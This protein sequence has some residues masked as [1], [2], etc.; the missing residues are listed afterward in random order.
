MGISPTRS[1]RVVPSRTASSVPEI[2]VGSA[3][4]ARWSTDET[5]DPLANDIRVALDSLLR[6]RTI[7][8]PGETVIARSLLGKGAD[9]PSLIWTAQACGA[10]F[11]MG[12][13]PDAP[14]LDPHL[15]VIEARFADGNWRNPLERA[16]RDPWVLRAR[17]ASWCLACLSEFQPVGESETGPQQRHR[18][19][20]EQAYDMLVGSPNSETPARWM[21]PKRGESGWSEVWPDDAQGGRT[22]RRLNLLTSLY[23]VLGIAR[24]ERHGFRRY[25]DA[26]QTFLRDEQ[27]PNLLVDRLLSQIHVETAPDGPLVRLRGEDEA[28]PWHEPWA[29]AR[30]LPP[31]VIGL[32]AL[33]LV[34]YARF[35]G[36]IVEPDRPEAQLARAAF[37]K[38]QRLGHALLAR[39]KLIDVSWSRGVD[40]FFQQGGEDSAWFVPSYSICLRAVLETGVATPTHP[41]VQDALETISTFEI[42][43]EAG[44]WLDP[45]YHT[46]LDAE[47]EAKARATSKT[48]RGRPKLGSAAEA[49]TRHAEVDIRLW[50]Q[51]RN[52]ESEQWRATAASVHAAAMALSATRRA[53]G[54]VDPRMMPRVRARE[55][56]GN[57]PIRVLPK[58][59][60]SAIKITDGWDRFVIEQRDGDGEK[61][62]CET[63]HSSAQ[64]AF[65]L[66]KLLDSFHDSG[67]TVDELQQA[68]AAYNQ[69][70]QSKA[71]GVTERG[72]AVE[73][74]PSTGESPQ[75]L[76]SRLVKLNVFFGYELVQTLGGEEP[77]YRITPG[78]TL[79]FVRRGIRP[80][81]ADT[82]A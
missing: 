25:S 23:A 35:I 3:G 30:T 57:E 70:R 7:T 67:G 62:Y 36:Q 37:M 1:G 31:S 74:V 13:T 41:L 38:A 78:T 8:T 81:D 64:G 6:T 34:E 4:G 77:R 19:L 53:W 21:A 50:A 17:H 61:A 16:F 54:R 55:G 5:D 79:H 59:P 47:A 80:E 11:E 12:F 63:S 2:D 75:S 65:A 44:G 33:A 56:R 71:K 46:G 29:R 9:S 15:S 49:G 52:G 82:T 45:T 28:L 14:C 51:K 60:F 68:L 42:E 26:W 66:L 10:L 24:S 58:P 22:H 18:R 20:V 48:T 72:D 27:P 73:D 40:A 69:K 43:P 39:P 76:R 32:S